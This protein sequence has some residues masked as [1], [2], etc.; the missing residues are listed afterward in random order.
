[1]GKGYDQTGY[2]LPFTIVKFSCDVNI[3]FVHAVYCRTSKEWGPLLPYFQILDCYIAIPI[4]LEEEIIMLN[5]QN[6][7]MNCLE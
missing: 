7:K 6:V 3:F 5:R 2:Y 4:N 1:M